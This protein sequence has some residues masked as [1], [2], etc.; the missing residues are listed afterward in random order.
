MVDTANVRRLA[1]LLADAARIL[2]QAKPKRRR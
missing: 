2:A 1:E